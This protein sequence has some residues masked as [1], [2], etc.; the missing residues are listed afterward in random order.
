MTSKNEEPNLESNG[1]F[2]AFCRPG[3]IADDFVICSDLM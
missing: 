1:E 2:K 3:L